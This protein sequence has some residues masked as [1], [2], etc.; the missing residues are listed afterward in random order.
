VYAYP[1]RDGD[2]EIFIQRNGVLEQVTNNTVDDASPWFDASSDTIVWHR[3]IDGRYHIISYNIIE[4]SEVQITT[5]D[6]NNMEPT[7]QGEYTVWQTWLDN[8]WEIVLYD[9]KEMYRITYSSE[10]DVAPHIRNGLLLWSQLD[11]DG[12]RLAYIYNIETREQIII[13]NTDNELITNARLMVVFDS[14]TDNG[15]VSVKGYDLVTGEIIPISQT[16]RSIP[17]E[18]PSP[19]P[20]D[21]PTALFPPNSKS[22]ITTTPEDVSSDPPLDTDQSASLIEHDFDDESTLVLFDYGVASST[23]TVLPVMEEPLSVADFTLDLRAPDPV[24]IHTLSV[25]AY[26]PTTSSTSESLSSS[27]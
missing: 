4:G 12:Q 22:D 20:V 15:D 18:I 27:Q 23:G 9:T 17:A 1:D 7:R 11:V 2:L 6:S 25:P 8:N 19:N 14:Q 24:A 21:E 26:D 13:E 3:L 5:G 16:D 10:A